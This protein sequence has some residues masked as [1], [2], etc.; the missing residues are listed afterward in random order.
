MSSEIASGLERTF[1]RLFKMLKKKQ[2][3]QYCQLEALCKK[4][5]KN[6]MNLKD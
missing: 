1:S 5:L 3:W 4:S 6:F 2:G